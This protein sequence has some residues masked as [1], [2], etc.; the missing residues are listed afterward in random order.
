MKKTIILL[1]LIAI[2]SKLFGFLRDISLSYF[3][4]ASEISDIYLISLTIPTVLIAIIGD[5]IST[6]FVPMY[7]RIETK[8]GL[9]KAN[10]YTNNLANFVL[11]ICIGIF[12]ISFIFTQPIVKLFASGF[13]T[14]TLELAVIFT[15]ITLVSVFFSGLIYVYTA[16]LQLKGIFAIPAIMGLPANIIIIVSFIAS[17]QTNI[18]VLAVG[19]M[20]ATVSQFLLLIVYCHKHQYRYQLRLD[21]K[22]SNLKKMMYLALPVILGSSAAQIN[23]LIDRTLASQVVVGG[24]SAL[25]YANT[26]NLVAIGVIVSSITSVL[27]PKISKAASEN[28]ITGIQKHLSNAMNTIHLF[29]LPVLIICLLFPKEIIQLL[30]GRGEFDTQAID[31]TSQAFLFYSI[32]LVGLSQ[33]E[34]F[35]KVF[36]SMQDTKTPMINATFS[37]I[38]NIILNFTLYRFLGIGGIALATSISVLFCSLLLFIQLK[39]RMGGF[40]V[41][42]IV[43]TFF[44][45]CLAAVAMGAVSTISYGLLQNSVASTLAF[46]L[47]VLVGLLLYIGIILVMRINEVQSVVSHV[48]FKRKEKDGIK[49]VS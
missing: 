4:G 18:Y 12:I 44:K 17:S 15:R 7:T 5:G 45:S 32:G 42:S 30:Y 31:T 19:S 20:V 40:K 26:T 6:G 9:E 23:L 47:A 11:L 1:M 16:F 38:I 21:I 3:Y 14:E 46:T 8:S 22:D 49:Q 43:I 41:K 10:Q 37:I 25:N 34:L 48:K 29:V 35:S 33:R 13:N 24:I 28:N 27:Y 39:K 36:Y 2:I